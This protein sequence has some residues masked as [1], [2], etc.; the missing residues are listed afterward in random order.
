MNVVGIVSEYNPF[1]TGHLYHVEQSRRIVGNGQP[2]A[3]VAVMSG[4]YVQ[5]GD[6]AAFPKHIRAEAACMSPGGPDLV[7]DLPTPFACSS[8]ER[9]ANAAVYLLNSTGVV[10]HISFG[11]E[12]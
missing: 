3:V 11:S 2:C 12:T 4:N 10:T 6:I 7:I 5:R 1:H 9:F 8:A